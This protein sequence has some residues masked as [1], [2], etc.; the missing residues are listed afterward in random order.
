MDIGLDML[1]KFKSLVICKVYS[2]VKYWLSSQFQDIFRRDV[3]PSVAG[4]VSIPLFI[5]TWPH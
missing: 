5:P 2:P 3:K 1:P 4:G